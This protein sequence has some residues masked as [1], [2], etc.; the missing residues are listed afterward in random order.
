MKLNLSLFFLLAWLPVLAQ[1]SDTTK[2]NRLKEVMVTNWY[3]SLPDQLR[4][5]GANTYL[6]E[7]DTK[8]QS[9][10]SLVGLLN[11]VAGVRME[12]R[13]PGS[14]R[15][16]MR[17][18]LLRSP[19]GIRNI[20]IYIDGFPL[21][22]AGGNSYLNLI[23]PA[24]L[25]AFSIL[26]GPQASTFGANT[27]GAISINTAQYRASEREFGLDAGSYGLF[28][29]YAKVV[30]LYKNYRFSVKEGYQ[31]RT[32]YREQSALSR[33]Y[34]QTTQEWL[35]SDR[36]AL[37]LLVFYSDLHYQT[38]GGLTDAQVQA[39]PRS[40]RPSTAATPSAVQ[41]N[42]G[43][44]NQTLYGGLS[45]RYRF[46]RHFQW[47]VSAFGSTTDYKNPFIT[48]FE[49]RKENTIG[50]RS[51]IAYDQAIGQNNLSAY[52]GIETA[53]TSTLVSNFNNKGG[54]AEALQS[55]DRLIARQSFG[56]IKINF[57]IN[58]RLMLELGSSLNGYGYAYDSY[59]PL[60]VDRQDRR[61]PVQLMPRFAASYLIGKDLSMKGSVS[62]G[63]SPPTI[64]EVRSAD[65]V[66]NTDLQAESGWNYEG[67]LSFMG[68]KGL[69]LNAVVFKFDL[70]HTIVRRLTTAD[71]EY[72]VNAGRTAQLGTELEAGYGLNVSSTEG[73]LRHIDFKSSFTYNHFRFKNL[74]NT[75]LTGVPAH[76][77]VS[78]VEF[79]FAKGL[80]LFAQ[81]NYTSAIPL[82][83]A[84]TVYGKSYH[85][86]DLKAGIRS[87]KIGGYQIDLCLGANNIFNASYSLGNDL[88]AANGRYYNPAPGAN[89]YGGLA[90]KF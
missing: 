55:N 62:R 63:Y 58:S 84:N 53:R 54:V 35:Y 33:K 26:K 32:G 72:F 34:I 60:L 6:D 87:W 9:Q 36:G 29:Q 86:A 79:L 81:H 25:S 61:F 42:A 17:G 74:N 2:T 41:Q 37:K 31:E 77:F 40:A 13:S 16:S 64:A 90:F 50:L 59:F 22:D 67:G 19:F 47:T 66:I 5:T 48:N 23:D 21:T 7:H 80:F 12:E 20:K 3:F 43:I 57:D 10:Q 88:N 15:L 1:V 38:P 14:Y 71:V 27:G 76:T 39:N 69:K 70:A 73:W 75:E 83:D 18:S 51:F 49:K 8:N 28:H 44:D 78:G 68:I 65:Q 45:N 4:E 52:I 89:Y 24:A 85:L 46:D 82:N 11:T 56:F 30:Q